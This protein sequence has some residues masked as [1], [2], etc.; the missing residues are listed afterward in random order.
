MLLNCGAREDLRIHWTARSSN[1]SVLKEANPEHSLEGLMLKAKLR[2]FG[3]LTRR[4]DSVE[5]DPDA[6][7]TE[8]R[9]RRGRN[10]GEMAGWHHR[11]H[12]HKLEQTPG[13]GGRWE[14]GVLQSTGLQR[15]GHDLAV[16]QRRHG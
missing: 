9:R 4:A 13:D 12:G 11:R 15:V 1:Q 2:Y 14:P 3:H 10:E 7:K 8:G 5:K 16:E 6:R